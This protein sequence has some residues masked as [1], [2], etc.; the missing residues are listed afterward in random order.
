MKTYTKT[1]IYVLVVLMLSM[2]PSSGGFW[3]TENEYPSSPASNWTLID[4]MSDTNTY[5]MLIPEGILYMTRTTM[6]AGSGLY[7]TT[8]LVFVP[9]NNASKVTI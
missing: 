2:I 1:L 6:S 9:S 5:V 3:T 4:E 7:Y 8:S